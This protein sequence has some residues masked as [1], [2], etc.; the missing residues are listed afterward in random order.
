[1]KI[2]KSHPDYNAWLYT[3]QL[4]RT[5]Y[6]YSKRNRNPFN[7]V[8]Y[9][10]A[11]KKL[12]RLGRRCGIECGE[13]VFDEGVRFFHT[14]GTVINGNA[15]VGK[16]CRLYGNN[17]IGNDGIHSKC[18]VIGD[19][20]RICVGAKIIGDVSIANNV[21]VAAGAVVNKDCLKEGVILAGI[22]AKIIG[23]VSSS[24]E[25]LD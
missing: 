4:R 16:N 22:P 14:Q 11:C 15:R 19:N 7:A 18:P 2:V 23:S 12:N 13:N 8:L 1:M 25:F 21:I 6:Y 5:S 3:K 20:V 10:C 24:K 17:C 9:L